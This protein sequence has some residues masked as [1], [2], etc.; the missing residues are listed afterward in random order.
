MAPLAV[1]DVVDPKR[2]MVAVVSAAIKV[3]TPC[4]ISLRCVRRI[5]VRACIPLVLQKIRQKKRRL[6][7]AVAGKSKIQSF[8]IT[9]TPSECGGTSSG[10]TKHIA[11]GTQPLGYLLCIHLS[12]PQ[13]EAF[14][15]D[16]PCFFSPL[17]SPVDGQ[18]NTKRI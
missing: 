3:C 17:Y 9:S 14:L 2:H 7:N 6:N 18:A 10:G 13:F 11:N 15:L 8:I 12:K 4:S 5:N 1:V 16:L